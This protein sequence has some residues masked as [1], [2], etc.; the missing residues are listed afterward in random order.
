MARVVLISSDLMLYATVEGA[1]RA[2]GAT[3]VSARGADDAVAALGPDA[4]LVAVDLGSFRGDLAA[5]LAACRAAAPG[6]QVVAF[7]PHVQGGLLKG[8]ADAGCDRVMARGAFCQEVGRL[9]EGALGAPP[10]QPPA[11]P[12][13]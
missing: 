1:A 13:S 6:A 4:G 10:A 11:Q 7:G 5:L 3:F 9:V 8:A 12:P 2:H